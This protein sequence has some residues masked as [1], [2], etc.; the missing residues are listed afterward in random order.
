M[1]LPS[2][3]RIATEVKTSPLP[4]PRPLW[5]QFALLFR[6]VRYS[7]K[8]IEMISMVI[9]MIKLYNGGAVAVSKLAAS[10]RRGSNGSSF[11]AQALMDILSK[12]KYTADLTQDERDQ[13]RGRDVAR[14]VT[15]CQ[16]HCPC[17]CVTEVTEGEV[18]CHGGCRKG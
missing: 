11:P 2:F 16:T 7:S 10:D 6:L 12:A 3:H 14:Q 18:C 8:P 9:I 15:Q 13:V 1:P 4:A 17:M 5:P